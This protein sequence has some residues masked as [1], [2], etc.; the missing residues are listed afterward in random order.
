MCLTLS[1][2]SGDQVHRVLPERASSAVTV[3][4]GSV[5]YMIPSTT[6]GVVST[7]P[8]PACVDGCIW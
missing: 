4:G 8:L 6:I 7:R 2:M 5:M 3:L 1:G